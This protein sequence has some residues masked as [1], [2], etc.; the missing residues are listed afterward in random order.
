M[1]FCLNMLIIAEF[2]SGQSFIVMVVNRKVSD[3]Q[4]T[5][6]ISSRENSRCSKGGLAHLEGLAVGQTG[7][8][9]STS[10]RGREG[11]VE[12]GKG[13][14]WQQTEGFRL[15]SGG[16]YSCL[17][18]FPQISSGCCL[19]PQAWVDPEVLYFWKTLSDTRSCETLCGPTKAELPR[20]VNNYCVNSSLRLLKKI[21]TSVLNNSMGKKNS[22]IYNILTAIPLV[23][24]V[25]R[26]VQ[27]SNL[28]CTKE[29][30]EGKL[31]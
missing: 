4:I 24:T 29:R 1:A 5:S 7:R 11:E 16:A 22:N 31:I 12:G 21:I 3:C 10:H 18:L 20:C 15:K 25:I 19:L 17:A 26:K 8:K 13:S 28:F 30:E 23:H 9:P 27:P 2:G 6:H 14:S